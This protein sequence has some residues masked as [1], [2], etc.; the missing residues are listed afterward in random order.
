M[1]DEEGFE[2][3]RTTTPGKVPEIWKELSETTCEFPKWWVQRECN[4]PFLSKNEFKTYQTAGPD[5][6]YH[7]HYKEAQT[8]NGD[9]IVLTALR[10]MV[11]RY[12]HVKRHC[13]IVVEVRPN[14]IPMPGRTSVYVDG[15]PVN[16]KLVIYSPK[17]NL[18]DIYYRK[19]KGKGKNKD[20]G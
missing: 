1:S 4:L 20:K 18:V 2:F 7:W 19:D 12:S 15:K 6:P 8:E 17:S 11:K 14:F 10:C 9:K 3:I 5:S 16:D 13:T